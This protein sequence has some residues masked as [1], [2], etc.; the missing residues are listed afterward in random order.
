M[1]GMLSPPRIATA[2]SLSRR[3]QTLDLA[4]PIAADEVIVH[5]SRRLH[6]R[7]A[8]GR[9]H[10]R[11]APRLQVAAQRPCGL[12]LGRHLPRCAPVILDRA[13]ADEG[14]EVRVEG[15]VFAL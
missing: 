11:K 8:D 2:D 15:A 10:E 14:P 3:R 5:H 6:E 7:V 9:A 12:R 13:A 1:F 4:P